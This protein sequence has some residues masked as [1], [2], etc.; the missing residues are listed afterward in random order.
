MYKL[1]DNKGSLIEESNGQ[2]LPKGLSQIQLH[3]T[4]L[5]SGFYAVQFTYKDKSIVKRFI[6]H[7]VKE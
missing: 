5:R 3:V 4:N 1:Y 6:K 2:I 7:S